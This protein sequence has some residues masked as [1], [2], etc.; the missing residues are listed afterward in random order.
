MFKWFADLRQGDKTVTEYVNEFDALSKYG[1][2]FINTE[3]KKND[4]FVSGPRESL[5]KHLLNHIEAH[6]AK[7]MSMALKHK[8]MYQSQSSLQMTKEAKKESKPLSGE[9]RKS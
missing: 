7:L 9:K 2:S 8:I 4:K 5:G 1:Y 6:F 3:E